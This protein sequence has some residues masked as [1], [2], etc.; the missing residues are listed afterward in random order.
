MKRF[1]VSLP[2]E[3]KKEID[4]FPDINWA[5]VAK[6]SIEKKVR[7]LEEFERFERSCDN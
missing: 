5:Q 1:T 2:D 3:L 4:A 7:M 6:E